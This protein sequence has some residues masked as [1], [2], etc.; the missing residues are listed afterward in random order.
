MRPIFK[1]FPFFFNFRVGTSIEALKTQLEHVMPAAVPAATAPLA[2]PAPATAP[3]TAPAAVP[4]AAE[5]SQLP[6]ATV[7]SSAPATAQVATVP[8]PVPVQQPPQP[9][10]QMPMQ[11]VQIVQNPHQV[12]QQRMTPVRGQDVVAQPQPTVQHQ[13]PVAVIQAQAGVVLQQQVV[14]A[15]DQQLSESKRKERDAFLDL[16]QNLQ[17]I[18]GNKVSSKATT[19][20]TP[21]GASL[22]QF[23]GQMQAQVEQPAAGRFSISPV[24]EQRPPLTPLQTGKNIFC[25]GEPY[26]LMSLYFT[27]GLTRQAQVVQSESQ[28]VDDHHQ[29]GDSSPS[30]A[31]SNYTTASESGQNINDH[32]E[33]VFV[34]ACEEQGHQQP[35]QP[36][37]HHHQQA[38]VVQQE[39]YHNPQQQPVTAAA[40]QHA[41]PPMEH[42]NQVLQQGYPQAQVPAAVP[43]IPHSQEIQHQPKQEAEQHEVKE[44]KVSLISFYFHPFLFF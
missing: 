26:V 30:P 35:E 29:G 34:Q 10:H 21:T 31:G 5:V 1:I 15:E 12:Q 36:A 9:V 7:V 28:L 32:S 2:T 17:N 40:V 41:Q 13:Q 37:V 14:P 18:M 42:Q 24:V 39:A 43:S 19:A 44:T 33:N 8:A 27:D 23:P 11:H 20:N 16:E 4:V 3:A 38:A 6:R 22:P 25:V